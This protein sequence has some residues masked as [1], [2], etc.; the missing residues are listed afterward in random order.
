MCDDGDT[1]EVFYERVI[2]ARKR[3]K[4]IECH[5]PIP[6]G[7]RYVCCSGIQDR[8]PFRERMHVEC[9]ALVKDVWAACKE[10]GFIPLGYLGEEINEMYRDDRE[11]AEPFR[12]RLIEI[13]R[14]YEAKT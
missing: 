6:A 3:H 8:E 11:T 9:A 7:V 1:A 13:K 4:C 2:R 5:A 14:A 12:V 10:P